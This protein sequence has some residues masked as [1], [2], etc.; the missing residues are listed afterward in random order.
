MLQP[1]NTIPD[2]HRSAITVRHSLNSHLY[3]I[4]VVGRT[5]S[6]CGPVA[7]LAAIP[8]LALGAHDW[9]WLLT[10]IASADALVLR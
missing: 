9:Q 10:L 8:L 7:L 4:S 3:S 6:D 5:T 1:W 2:K